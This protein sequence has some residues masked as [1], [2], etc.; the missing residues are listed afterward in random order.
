LIY[1]FLK[2]LQEYTGE[3]LKAKLVIIKEVWLCDEGCFIIIRLKLERII[4]SQ[5]PS[6]KKYPVK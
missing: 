2:V 3:K 1:K 6:I 4:H 5:Y